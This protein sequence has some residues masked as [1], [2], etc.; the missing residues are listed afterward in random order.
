MRS[1]GGQCVRRPYVMEG[2]VAVF[3]ERAA[4][5]AWYPSTSPGLPSSP[6]SGEEGERAAMHASY[7]HHSSEGDSLQRHAADGHAQA[8]TTYVEPD[9]YDANHM[10]LGPG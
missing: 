6:T 7:L 1:V 2:G 8:E 10:V 5:Y 3:S 9:R 4:E